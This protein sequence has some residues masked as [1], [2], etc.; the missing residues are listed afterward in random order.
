MARKINEAGRELVKSFEG[1]RLDSYICAGGVRTIGWGSTGPHVKEGMTISLEEAET[2]L[3]T[4][5]SRFER[6]VEA[7]VGLHPTNQDQ[8]SAFVS[9][10]FN[11]GLH[12]LL[13]ST[14]LKRHKARDYQAAADQ[15][16]EWNKARVNGQLVPL[17]GLTARREAERKLYL[18]EA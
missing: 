8:F 5:L 6:G 15:F 18:G 9:F 16:R 3:S 17:A 2:L 12:A 1:L 7:I 13:K 14:L 10:T 11:L 4:D